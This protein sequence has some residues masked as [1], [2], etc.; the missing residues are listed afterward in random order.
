MGF[1][2]RKPTNAPLVSSDLGTGIVGSTNIADNAV[3]TSKIADGTIT[4]DDLSAT[5]TKD[6][7]TF[8]RG[9]N[10][11]AS[12]AGIAWQSVQTTSFT[13]SAGNAYPCNTTSAGFTVTLPATP[14][15]GDQVQLVDYA[16]TFDT[17]VL[18]INPNG[19]DIEGGTDNL[20]LTGEREGVI[21]T[22]IDSTQG[23]IATSGINEGTDALAPVTYPVNFLVIAGGGGGG[24]DGGCG[25]GA[26]GYRNSFSTESSGG[27][28]SSEE[29]LGFLVGV[30]YTVTV[31]AGGASVLSPVGNSGNGTNSSISGTGITTITSIGGGGSPLHNT[32]GQS[33]GSGSGANGDSPIQTVGAGTANQGFN[34]GNATPRGGGGGAGEAGDTDGAWIWRRWIS[35]FYYRFICNKSRWWCW[36]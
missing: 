18:V 33:G 20:Q 12:V 14:S 30:V 4:L 10:T 5:G 24:G 29:E 28:G 22:Y 25:G 8:L 23:W 6:A 34:G 2:G 7:T 9:D 32:A 19:E 27:G 16:G 15:A 21:L 36:I 1:I 31:G 13:A 35:F 11:F 17:N 26:G 3:L